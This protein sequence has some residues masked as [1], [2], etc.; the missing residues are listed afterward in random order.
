MGLEPS[1]SG[2]TGRNFHFT[3]SLDGRIIRYGLA[4][5]QTISKFRFGEPLTM[6]TT[7]LD[8]SNFTSRFFQMAAER[9][10]RSLQKIMIEE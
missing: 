4:A 3:S 8:Y 10:F 2:V 9:Y 1:P 6:D 7:I 5:G